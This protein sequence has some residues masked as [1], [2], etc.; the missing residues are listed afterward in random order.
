M[1][2]L[3][4]SLSDLTA[5]A[6]RQ[7]QEAANPKNAI[8]LDKFGGGGALGKAITQST[9]LLAYDLQAPSK[10]LFPVLTPLRN[11][12]PRVGGGGG[13]ATNWKAVTAINT[14]HLRGFI[15]EGERNGL[16]ATSVVPKSATY[17]FFG[18]EDSV[19]YE[20]ELG[21]KGFEDVRARNAQRLLWATM[22]EEEVA[23]LGA[24]SSV[25]LGTPGTI[26]V[27]VGADGTIP[28]GTYLSRVVALTHNGW[29][30]SSLAGGVP[31]LV[32]V[33]PADGSAAFT[34]GGGSSQKSAQATTGVLG[35]A[36]NSISL[37]VPVVNGAVAY[38]W[39]VDDGAAGTMTLQAITSINSVKLTALTTT[40]M[41]IGTVFDADHSQNTLAY[42]GLLYHAYLPANSAYIKTMATGTPGTGTPLTS[43]GAGGIVEIDDVLAYLWDNLRLSPTT[44]RVHRQEAANITKKLVSSGVY[45]VDMSMDR[46]KPAAIDR[47][48]GYPNKFAGTGNPEI[49]I[50]IHPNLTPGAMLFDIDQLPY[51]LTDIPNVVEKRLRRDYYQIEWPQRKRK[52][53]SGVYFDGVLAHY[54]PA[55]L[56]LI[57]NIANG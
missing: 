19:T 4:K 54:F 51:P 9:G 11:R 28:A 26:T 24:N 16:V 40:G 38:A 45:R 29:L 53:E 20:A 6:I 34:Y 3:M 43:D 27:A 35:G 56:A 8:P 52:Y 42:D 44:I 31:G 39:F 23:D 32:T 37:S 5:E 7:F 18:L 17:K 41:A 25:A 13:D 1:S 21:G 48:R 30:A 36:T 22:I 10:S 46:P 33:N 47:V 55:A 49:P 15:P 14:S 57:A 12:I 2:L 50:E